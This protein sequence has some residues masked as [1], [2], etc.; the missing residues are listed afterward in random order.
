MNDQLAFHTPNTRS[1]LRGGYPPLLR[2]RGG[3]APRQRRRVIAHIDANLDRPM[4]CAELAEV[5]VMSTSHFHRAFKTSIGHSPHAYLTKQRLERAQSLLLAT[6]QPLAQIALAC[7][8]SDQ[9]HLCRLFRKF[10]GE[11]PA[12]WRRA[13]QS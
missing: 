6:S 11:S 8:L 4:T 9:C 10:M 2:F 1:A 12:A 13:R 3:L 7:G 5:V